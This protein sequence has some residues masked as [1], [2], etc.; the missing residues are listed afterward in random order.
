[1]A[2]KYPDQYYP[3][4]QG[5]TGRLVEIIGRHIPESVELK[6]SKH[7]AL[8]KDIENELIEEVHLVEV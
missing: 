1:M 6:D 5:L 7:I 4:V 8:Q 3:Y 2:S